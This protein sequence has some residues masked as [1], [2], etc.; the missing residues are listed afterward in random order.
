MDKEIYEVF[1]QLVRL[2]IVTSKSTKIFATVDW[3]AVKSIADGQ[4]LTAVVLDGID[5]LSTRRSDFTNM[6]QMMRLE[7]IG[8][9]L[10]NYEMRYKSYEKAIGSLAGWYN[11]H[12]FKMMVLKGYSSSLNWPNP[13]HRPC[14]D[15]DIWLFGKQKEADEALQK[16]SRIGELENKITINASHHHHTV[17]GWEGFSVENYFDFVNVHAERSSKAIETVFKE[18]GKD[19]STFIEIRG[20]NVYLPSPN[21]H[22]LFL[23]RHLVSHFASS[24]ITLRQVLDWAFF[25]EKNTDGI[26]WGWLDGMVKK[27][28]MK[29]F[30]NCINAICVEEL[31]FPSSIFAFGVQFDPDIKARILQ[32]ILEPKF[33]HI[34]PK[35]LGKRLVYKYR[36]WQ[37]NAWKQRLCYSESR[38]EI[39]ITGIWAKILKPAGL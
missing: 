31:G 39:F 19:D 30:I 28:N 36:R 17:F 21:L 16:S 1:F 15:I 14:G 12:G 3:S 18:L 9:V 7:W 2:G 8:E 6:S 25:V 4:G 22:A 32:D 23:I 20:E 37:G 26:D 10:Q 35:S 13:S 27:F 5:V 11:L 33:T 24:E 38:W 29:D 34:E